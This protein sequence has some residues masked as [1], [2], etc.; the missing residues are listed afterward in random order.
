MT[1]IHPQFGSASFDVSSK[2]GFMI[3]SYDKRSDE[4]TKWD[5]ISEGALL[6]HIKTAL[7]LGYTLLR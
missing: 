7:D 5:N 4:T 3:L 1:L 2:G 6:E